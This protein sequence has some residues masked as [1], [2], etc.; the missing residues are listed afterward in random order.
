MFLTPTPSEGYL[1]MVFI[2]TLWL[3]K[4]ENIRLVL[5][6][7]HWEFQSTGASMIIESP[8]MGAIWASFF[9]NCRLYFQIVDL[10][11][12]CQKSQVL[13]ICNWIQK[14]YTDIQ[15]HC[16]INWL[17]RSM[18]F[19]SGYKGD[20]VCNKNRPLIVCWEDLK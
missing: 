12:P 14:G 11:F 20:H 4:K 8:W 10:I 9:S 13:H 19:L 17:L 2:L 7:C 3:G 15:N 1:I 16:N 18:T 5:Q 6:G